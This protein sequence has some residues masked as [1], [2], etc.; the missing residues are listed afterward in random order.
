M[1]YRS[2]CSRL[3]LSGIAASIM[4]L[5]IPASAHSS[6]QAPPPQNLPRIGK[7]LPR[8]ED[9]TSAEDRQLNELV[10]KT[11]SVSNIGEAL[12]ALD[13]MLGRLREP[14]QLRGLIQFFR[15]TAL[16]NERLPEA[17]EAVEES[18]RLLPG[19]SAP[20]LQAAALYAY[21][22][23]PSKG[24]D[25][26]LRAIQLDP[27]TV[28][29]V[30]D[31]EVN[32]IMRRL[33]FARD[34]R[35]SRAIG[36]R[37]LEIGWIGDNLDSRSNLALS[38]IGRRMDEGDVDGARKLVTKLTVPKHSYELL[39]DK[40]YSV[41]WPD[42]EAWTGPKLRAQWETYLREA[43]D[44]WEASKATSSVRDYV[45]A[46]RSAGHDRTIIRDIL[47]VYYAKL[48]QH[49]DQDLQFAISGVADALAHEGKWSE[50]NRVFARA[51]EVWP[52]S[53]ENPNS[54]NIA[55]NWA[56]YL[57]FAGE[58][59]RALDK[60]DEAVGFAQEWK[61]NPDAIATMHLYRACA[62]HELGR[63]RETAYPVRMAA[64]MT[65]PAELAWLHLCTS[66]RDSALRVLLEGL[67]HESTR[68]NVLEFAQAETSRPRDSDYSR[69][70]REKT[71]ELRRDPQ[72]IVQVE[73]Y[74]RI[75]PYS[76]IEGAPPEAP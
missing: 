56:R 14:T 10:T 34:E 26:F 59:Q 11:V 31:Y 67:K 2:A 22:N 9:F 4:L 60:M 25:Y 19:Y 36:E 61:V 27:A 1:S 24:G 52:L 76:D 43:R 41:I 3:C 29:T 69:K 16:S 6:S 51:Q 40:K 57:L 71:D 62:L 49:Q 39:L 12:P 8:P 20:L 72:L 15:A 32:N 44:R 54:L 73:K 50:V 74:G 7:A 66:D 38:A 53:P 63:D 42:L 75:M 28:R 64:L 55:A 45:S 33:V 47:P 5:P 21:S 37:L 23:E 18:I 58:Y 13:A 48:D 70:M 30:E 65:F 17:L 68:Q 46:L 35:R